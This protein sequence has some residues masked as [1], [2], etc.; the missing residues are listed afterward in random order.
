MTFSRDTFILGAGVTG[1]AAAA[2]TG[3]TVFEAKSVP[4]GICSSYYMTQDSMKRLY[5]QD[6]NRLA[7]RFEMGGGHWIFGADKQILQF[8]KKFTHIK[9][10]TRH[11]SV[12]FNKENR[13][14]PYPIQNNLRF[15]DRGLSKKI[16]KEILESPKVPFLTQKQYLLKSFGPILC[17]LFFFPFNSLYTADL[18]EDIAAQESYKTPMDTSLVIQGANKEVP[19]AGYNVKFLYPQQG[20]DILIKNMAESCDIQYKKKVSGIDVK[21]KK[22][23]FEDG[24]IQTY[25]RLISTLPLNKMVEMASLKIEGEPPPYTSV[26]V[27]NIGATCGNNCPNEH[28]LYTHDNKC[29]FH[30]V[31]FYSNVDTSFLPESS[32]ETSNRVSIYVER[33]YRGGEKPTEETVKSY[34]RSVVEELSKWEFI[35]DV[36]VVDYNWIEVAYTWLWPDSI[37]RENALQ[38]LEKHNIQ[39]LGRYGRWKFQGIADSLKE[40]LLCTN[41]LCQ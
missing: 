29:G 19:L 27:L 25:N 30:R 41:R 12:Y 24:S 38:K 15:L 16:L 22:I 26:L 34:V 23:Y 39:Q 33:A 13:Y 1:L 37:W 18:Y 20:L 8:L 9:E 3:A 36:E 32:Q 11:S 40:G 10:Y 2:K 4:G 7:Y 31:G 28:W 35:K 14:V 17:E 6:S 21:A 5:H